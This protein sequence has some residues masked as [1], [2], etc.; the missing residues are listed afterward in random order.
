VIGEALLLGRYRESDLLDKFAEAGVLSAVRRRGFEDITLD[1]DL[2]IGVLPHVRLHGRRRGESHLLLDA[3]LSE[4]RMGE[5]DAARCG[6]G[7]APPIDLLVVY[8]LRQQDPTA[9]FEDDKPRLPLQDHPGLGVLRRAF[10]VVLSIAEELGKHGVAALPKFFHDASIFWHSR[11][12]LFLD[13]SQQG[14]FEALVRDLASLPLADASLAVAG[15]A[16][17]DEEGVPVQWHLGFQ[18]MPLACPLTDWFHSPA[19]QEACRAHFEASR[20]AVDKGALESARR[21]FASSWS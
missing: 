8:W 13:P 20:F 7:G 4:V 3:C 16:V 10:R 17:R 12:F 5:A 14:R 21:V 1:F 2:D 9:A 18:V 6:Y 11:L 19:Y 15:G